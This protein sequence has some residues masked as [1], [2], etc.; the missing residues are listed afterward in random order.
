M[1]EVVSTE[2][3]EAKP[4]TWF[5]RVEDSTQ[6]HWDVL[7]SADDDLRSGLSRRV[8]DHMRLLDVEDEFPTT[9]LE[10]CL[11]AATM[12]YRD[13]RDDEYI[14][15]ALLHDIGD[16]LGAYNH[17]DIAAAIIKP[18]ARDDYLWMI[19][20]HAIFQGY[21]FWH[22]VGGD[23]NTRDQ[24]KDHPYYDLT[25]EFVRL[26]DMPAFDPNYDWKPLDEFAPLLDDFFREPRAKREGRKTLA[27]GE[28]VNDV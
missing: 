15:M 3:T 2:H 7:M 1:T 14:V 20:K 13:N 6:E 24:F 16:T 28:V 21:Y 26:Y 19:E 10:H 22:F 17:P 23:R 12:A 27:N 25:E 8:L 11:Q 5:T 18:F 4:F 9:R